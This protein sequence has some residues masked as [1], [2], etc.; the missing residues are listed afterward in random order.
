MTKVH[1]IILFLTWIVY[2][3]ILELVYTDLWSPSLILFIQISGQFKYFP[4][5]LKQVWIIGITTSFSIPKH[6]VSV[7]IYMMKNLKLILLCSKVR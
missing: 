2:N 6:T 7:V 3:N 5:T 1:I 4:L